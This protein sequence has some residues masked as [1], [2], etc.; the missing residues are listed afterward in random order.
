[1]DD[2]LRAGI[3]FPDDQEISLKILEAL[4]VP[5]HAILTIAEHADNTRAET[6]T[7]ARF[8]KKHPARTLIVVTS[9]SHST[10]AEKI[11]N[12]SLGPGVRVLMDPVPSDPF[13]PDRWWKDR[14]DTK[15]VL[16]EYGGL[17]DYWRLRL[18]AGLVGHFTSVPPPVTV[19]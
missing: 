4:R 5:R 12:A 3:Q 2:L 17:A 7:V 11:L 10:R 16:H 8:L 1:L 19:R 15:E 6:E 14:T 18:W 9:K 13:R